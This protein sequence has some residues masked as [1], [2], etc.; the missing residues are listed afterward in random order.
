MSC[1]QDS[2]V[3]KGR[4]TEFIL[5]WEFLASYGAVNR[6]SVLLIGV[7]IEQTTGAYSSTGKAILLQNIND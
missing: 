6:P 1:L 2:K 7:E 4:E 3:W 5:I